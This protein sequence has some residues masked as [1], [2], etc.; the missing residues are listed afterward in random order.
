MSAN[1]RI[2][3]SGPETGQLEDFSSPALLTALILAQATL[4]RKVK[5]LVKI[6]YFLLY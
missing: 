4:L 6:S 5:A 1:Q 2:N 3:L